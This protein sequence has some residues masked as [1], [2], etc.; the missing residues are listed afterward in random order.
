MGTMAFSMALFCL[1]MIIQKISDLPLLIASFTRVETLVTAL[2]QRANILGAEESLVISSQEDCRI[3]LENVTLLTPDH[4]R[5]LIKNA[6]ASLLS[7]EGMLIVGESG[8]GKS[9]L[10]RAI[11]GLWNAGEGQITHPPFGEMFFLPQR[12][13]MI[14]GTLRE[15]MLYPGRDSTVSDDTLNDVLK[16]VN[17]ADMGERF[18]GFDIAMDWP[19]LLSLGEQQRLSFA[20]LLLTNPR[21]A[22]LDEATSAL[23]ISNEESLYKQLQESGM[24]YVSVGHRPSLVTYHDNVLELQGNTNWRLVPAVG[25]QIAAEG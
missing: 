1:N 3:A 18:G 23:D 17:L 2:D 19:Q 8:T 5:T 22:I 15:Q 10:L 12:P 6:T 16:K 24:T 13:Y 4:D 7:G 11:A 14:H 9:S 20:R 21:Y 25:F